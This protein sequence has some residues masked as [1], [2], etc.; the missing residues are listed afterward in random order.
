MSFRPHFETLFPKTEGILRRLLPNL[1]KTGERKQRLYSGVIISVLLYA[2]PVWWNAVVENVRIGV[3]VQIL[4]RKI[5]IRVC[6]AYGAVSFHEPIM[7]VGIISHPRPISEL[8]E[9][10]AVVRDTADPVAPRTKAILGALARRK[11]MNAWT[12]EVLGLV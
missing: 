6:C 3:A 12:T 5:V 2:A 8:A 9:V 7:N 10:Y 4:Q 1:H 11:A